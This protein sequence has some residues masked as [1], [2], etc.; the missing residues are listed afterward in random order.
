M[1]KENYSELQATGRVPATSETFISPSGEYASQYEG[2]TVRFSV[3]PGETEALAEIGVRDTSALASAAYPEM[4]VVSSGWTS[5]SAFFK[6]EGGV[7]NIGL[8]RSPALDIFNNSILGY[9]VVP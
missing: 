5:T 3:Q 9:G 4:P 8:G 1:S 6:G 7:I 2:V